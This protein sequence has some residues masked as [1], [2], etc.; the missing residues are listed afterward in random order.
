MISYHGNQKEKFAKKDRK[1]QL[2]RSYVGD[3]AETLQNFYQH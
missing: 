2:L 1:N 3:N